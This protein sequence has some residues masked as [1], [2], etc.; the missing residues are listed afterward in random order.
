MEWSE[1]ASQV[2]SSNGW[3]QVIRTVG[4]VVPAEGFR[5]FFIKAFNVVFPKLKTNERVKDTSELFAYIVNIATSVL[6][7]YLAVSH[8]SL[9]DYIEAFCYGGAA[10][11]LHMIINNGKAMQVIKFILRIK[12]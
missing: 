6:L 10:V 2:L 1:V 11:F 8:M 12:K 5:A 9:K 3:G 4:I 7:S